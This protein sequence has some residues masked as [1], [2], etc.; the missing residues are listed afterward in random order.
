MA[1]RI[2]WILT[3]P[4]N[5]DE[6]EFEVNPREGGAPTYRKNLTTKTT[7]APGGAGRTIL[8]EGADEPK[9]FDCQGTL[10]TEDQYNTLVEWFDKRVLVTLEDDYGR[11][12][13][14]YITS[15]DPKR[16]PKPSHPWKHT[17][18]FTSVVVE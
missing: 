12:W 10:L 13:T 16:D 15:F 3:D 11:V 4:T 2:P 7:S 9:S 8:F 14:I 5:A 17:Y 1:I 6:Y 18:S